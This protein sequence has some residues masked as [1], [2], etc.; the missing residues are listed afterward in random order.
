MSKRFKYSFVTSGMLVLKISQA[1]YSNP[2]AIADMPKQTELFV[3][4]INR[5]A[6]QA[7]YMS[8]VADSKKGIRM[9]E[10]YYQ[11]RYQDYLNAINKNLNVI[12]DVTKL[13]NEASRA[14]GDSS[15]PIADCLRDDR[16]FRGFKEALSRLDRLPAYASS[17]VNAYD[18]PQMPNGLSNDYEKVAA[19]LDVEDTESS[20]LDNIERCCRGQSAQARKD[21]PACD[22]DYVKSK[23]ASLANIE[24][25]PSNFVDPMNPGK[26]APN[27]TP[28]DIVSLMSIG[29]M[30]DFLE[31]KDYNSQVRSLIDA[32]IRC[33]DARDT[34]LKTL[35]KKGERRAL[36]HTGVQALQC[37][38][39]TLLQNQSKGIRQMGLAVVKSPMNLFGVGVSSCPQEVQDAATQQL[40]YSL[41]AFRNDFT[42]LTSLPSNITNSTPVAKPVDFFNSGDDMVLD[43]RDESGMTRESLYISSEL[44]PAYKNNLSLGQQ[45]QLSVAGN[46]GYTSTTNTGRSTGSSVVR[47]I[48]E[49]RGNIERTQVRSLAAKTAEGDLESARSLAGSVRSRKDALKRKVE[50]ATNDKTLAVSRKN[51][52]ASSARGLVSKSLVTEAVADVSRSF[53]K[54]YDTLYRAIGLGTDDES[55]RSVERPGS[56]SNSSGGTTATANTSA[57]DRAANAIYKE[58][59]LKKG[60]VKIR[61][62]IRTMGENI[63][64]TAAKLNTIIVEKQALVQKFKMNFDPGLR[65]KQLG[66]M[67]FEDRGD[68]LVALNKEWARMVKEI[69]ILNTQELGLRA[70]ISTSKMSFQSY[71]SAAQAYQGLSVTSGNIRA[72]A[73]TNPAIYQQNQIQLQMPQL[74]TTGASPITPNLVAPTFGQGLV[75]Q[76]APAT[77]SGFFKVLDFLALPTAYAAPTQ[78]QLR[79]KL[80]KEFRAF[81]KSYGAF[82]DRVDADHVIVKQE[83]WDRYIVNE[84]EMRSEAVLSSEALVILG[85]FNDAVREEIPSLMKAKNDK[86]SSGTNPQIYRYIEQIRADSA[87][88]NELVAKE[89]MLAIEKRSMNPTDDDE[90]W[91]GMLP[92]IALE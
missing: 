22:P 84:R 10:T 29:Q 92:A 48:G 21:F 19:Y 52:R 75:Q 85:A 81:M 54:N 68:K 30:Q 7:Q 67:G 47:G 35:Q 12:K 65:F 41:E 4:K 58:E 16:D 86:I 25:L 50:V 90:S 63:N 49:G 9:L 74:T 56:G 43:L 51:T 77:G 18:R 79:E 44:S 33:Q 59:Q 72:P 6:D 5:S 61:N 20:F 11:N 45:A 80:N 76:T 46:S 87:E 31:A 34:A 39:G 62:S 3:Q 38:M 28:E 55:G 15:R 42:H 36:W 17:A 88:L 60:L 73:S 57:S 37:S 70:A 27:L 40:T 69:N 32:D 53:K 23:V 82:V 66:D 83:A 8:S 1:G 13:V 91:T 24:K 64:A 89:A 71:V 14:G 2:G 78:A 26:Y